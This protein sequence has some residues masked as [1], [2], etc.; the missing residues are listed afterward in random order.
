MGDRVQFRADLYD[1]YGKMRT[2]GCDEV[3]MRLTSPTARTS[4][5][6]EVTDMRNGS[7][8]G[9]TFLQWQGATYVKVYLTYPREFLRQA[10][11][12]RLTALATR[13]CGMSFSLDSKVGLKKI[14]CLGFVCRDSL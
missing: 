11:R 10:V 7:Y 3:R 4:V 13:W 8:L 14:F 1:G 6:A 2:S 12:I 5:A 9:T